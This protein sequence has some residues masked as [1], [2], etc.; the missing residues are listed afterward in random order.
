MHWPKNRCSSNL[1]YLVQQCIVHKLSMIKEVILNRQIVQLPSVRHKWLLARSHNSR[2]M[3]SPLRVNTRG[4]SSKK[5]FNFM[6]ELSQWS[7]GSILANIQPNF[8]DQVIFNTTFYQICRHM[9]NLKCGISNKVRKRL[10]KGS[11]PLRRACL[12]LSNYVLSRN[13]S[14]E[15]LNKSF[16]Y[17]I[18][19]NF[20]LLHLAK[21]NFNILIFQ[22]HRYYT[23]H[24]A[25]FSFLI[26]LGYSDIRLI[27]I[28]T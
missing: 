23:F 12:N 18:D 9:R 3:T 2:P 5:T 11:V 14:F 6:I 10:F 21:V 1:V 13:T 24:A 26:I 4:V 27:P 16:P 28:D 7:V 25:E 22:Q 20:I 19:L 17:N 15:N 8:W